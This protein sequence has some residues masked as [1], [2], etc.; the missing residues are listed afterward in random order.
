M[1]FF[2]LFL[3][4]RPVSKAVC[5]MIFLSQKHI[6]THGICARVIILT[7]AMIYDVQHAPLL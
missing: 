4:L 2:S 7:T 1:D 6:Q 5:F 3:N